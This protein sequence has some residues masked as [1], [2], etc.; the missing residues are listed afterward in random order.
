M[1]KPLPRLFKTAASFIP[2]LEGRMLNTPADRDIGSLSA[3]EPEQ[4]LRTLHHA[5]QEAHPEAGA[6]YWRVRCWG[7][8]CWQPIYLALICVYQLKSVPLN[9]KAL[10]QNQQ[11]TMVAGYQLP[12]GEWQ[13][14]DKEDLIAVICQQLSIFF[15]EFEEAHRDLFGGRS[16][17]YQAL[18]ADQLLASLIVAGQLLPEFNAAKISAE[19]QRWAKALKLPLTPLKGFQNNTSAKPIF[20][21]QTCCLHFRRSDGE[22]CSNCPRLQAK[23]AK[24]H[25]KHQLSA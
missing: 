14:G 24:E 10:V 20:V 22:L 17:L 2:I 16:V 19:F 13:E 7:L 9:L 25:K 11:A 1:E 8:V 18:L 21:R 23:H 5:L 15:T 6:P 12:D 3:D 4:A